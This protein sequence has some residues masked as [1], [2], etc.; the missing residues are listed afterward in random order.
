M[1]TDGQAFNKVKN[2]LNRMDRSIDEARDKR[3]GRGPADGPMI[4]GVTHAPVIGAN[5]AH[6]GTQ[7]MNQTIGH[8][9]GH[10]NGQ[11][12]GQ[13]NGQSATLSGGS[14]AY[15]PG[16]GVPVARPVSTSI[17]P[18]TSSVGGAGAGGSAGDTSK[19]GYGRAKPLAR[20][21]QPENARRWGA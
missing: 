18:G 14:T 10:A 19:S 1:A 15:T 13:S 9:N 2:L 11:S 8:S 4:G 20:P 5:P 12:Q 17:Q 6:G 3:L 7:A 16:Q 21:A